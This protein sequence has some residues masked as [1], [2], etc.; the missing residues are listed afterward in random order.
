M[1]RDL[2][3]KLRRRDPR[4]NLPRPGLA[5]A[6]FNLARIAR[7]RLGRRDLKWT[8]WQPGR[9]FWG[10]HHMAEVRER[11]HPRTVLPF[12]IAL[13][14]LPFAHLGKLCLLAR[15]HSAVLCRFLGERDASIPSSRP[16]LLLVRIPSWRRFLR[17][18]AFRRLSKDRRQW[19]RDRDCKR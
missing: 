14:G 15:R 3:R 18:R 1:L 4:G 19:D 10:A 13:A 5:A 7:R 11:S 6:R 16:E 12:F 9:A 8:A 2:S 17:Y